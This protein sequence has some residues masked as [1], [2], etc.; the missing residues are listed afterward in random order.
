M[1]GVAKQRLD[2]TDGDEREHRRHKGVGRQRERESGLAYAP[3][4]DKNDH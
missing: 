3:Q 2:E 4:I 1:R